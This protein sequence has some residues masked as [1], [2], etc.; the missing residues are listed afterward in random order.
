MIRTAF[1]MFRCQGMAELR[2]RPAQYTNDCYPFPMDP[3]YVPVINPCR[4]YVHTF[5]Y[6][7][8]AAAPRAYLNF[9][10]VDSCF[11]VWLNGSFVGYSQVS[12][13]RVNLMS[14]L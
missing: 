2:L 3:P 8:N 9:E 10:G 12:T 11:Y 5:Y 13:P 14:P 6:E 7:K 1:K 4:A